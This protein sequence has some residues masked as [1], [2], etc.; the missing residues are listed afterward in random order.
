MRIYHDLS[1]SEIV[2]PYYIVFLEGICVSAECLADF[3]STSMASD[4]MMS[5]RNHLFQLDD[6]FRTY[7]GWQADV[8]RREK[9]GCKIRSFRNSFH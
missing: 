1:I 8:A 5:K 2:I 9:R 3:S 4:E 6:L 7:S